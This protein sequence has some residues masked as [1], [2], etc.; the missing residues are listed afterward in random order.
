[1]QVPSL[2]ASAKTA[3]ARSVGPA[4][5]E[6]AGVVQSTWN[7]HTPSSL[8]PKAITYSGEPAGGWRAPSRS[9]GNRPP[10]VA[11]VLKHCCVAAW[12]AS[13]LVRS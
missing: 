8:G 9:A 6:L 11:L 5:V 2:H 7:F 3:T 12:P 10:Q 4:K 1:M 13:I